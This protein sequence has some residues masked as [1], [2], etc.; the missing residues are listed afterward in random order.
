MFTLRT[1]ARRSARP[2]RHSPIRPAGL[3]EKIRSFRPPRL[4]RVCLV[5]LMLMLSAAWAMVPAAAQPASPASGAA[6]RA[7]IA[8]N[9]DLQPARAKRH[10][11]RKRHTRTVKPAAKQQNTQKAA[12]QQQDTEEA[13][14]EKQDDEAARRERQ[15]RLQVQSVCGRGLYISDG[16]CCARGTIWNGRR[17]LR[18]AGLQPLCP[19][20][21]TDCLPQ[22]PEPG[23]PPGTF[24][25]PP[26][27]FTANSCPS[28]F[29]GAPPNCQRVQVQTCPAGTSGSYP[30][31]EP[32]ARICP[33]GTTGVPPICRL[34]G[35]GVC[36]AGTVASGGICTVLSAP[37][38]A[39]RIPRPAVR[40]P[41]P[42]VNLQRRTLPPPPRVGIGLPDRLGR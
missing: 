15:E 3:S 4:W 6:I 11:K 35:R 40:T 20:G 31:C 26:N 30:N 24:G 8:A 22:L 16:H 41:Q 36:P 9:G 32:I 27:C 10:P 14:P 7:A 23:C 34:V 1:P 42:R 2:P 38:R 18:N 37:R 13:A 21:G 28:G 17:C 25:S 33:P 39:V 5:L 12:P 19:S 29:A